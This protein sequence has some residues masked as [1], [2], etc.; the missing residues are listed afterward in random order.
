M[1]WWMSKRHYQNQADN[2]PLRA[3]F[4]PMKNEITEDRV[5]DVQ[6]KFESRLSDIYLPDAV[7]GK[8]MYIYKNLMSVWYDKLSAENR[9]DDTMIQKFRGDWLEYMSALRDKS[10]YTYLSSE[11]TEKDKRE[12]YRNDTIIASKKV[13]ATEEAFA[14]AIGK[15]ASDEL[16]RMRGMNESA[17]SKEGEFIPEGFEIN[18]EGKIQPKTKKR[19]KSFFKW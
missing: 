18:A 5:I 10:T 15:E 7:S 16:T 1:V 12:S 13:F 4:L 9:Y 8:E 2:T 14:S 11:S 19:I 3:E 6:T 17:F